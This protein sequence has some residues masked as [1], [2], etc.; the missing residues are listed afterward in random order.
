MF[1]QRKVAANTIGM[2][3]REKD[4]DVYQ[5]WKKIH[6]EEW[7]KIFPVSLAFVFCFGSLVL[8]LSS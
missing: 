4:R 2:A 7:F 1:T 6:Q 3:I 5:G 8:C